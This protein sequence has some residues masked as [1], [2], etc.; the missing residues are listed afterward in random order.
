MSTKK[1][2]NKYSVLNK[3]Q[4]AVRRK[5]WIR[6]IKDLIINGPQAWRG[7]RAGRYWDYSIDF[8]Q[9][10]NYH[11]IGNKAAGVVYYLL[12][13]F[14]PLLMLVMFFLAI[15]GRNIEITPETIERF[16]SF[17]PAP[18]LVVIESLTIT[19]QS[20]LSTI[21]VLITIGMALWATS[22]GIG[23]V[24]TGI[25]SIY[26][27]REN[28]L[29]LPARMI[30]IVFTILFFILLTLATL[31]MSFGRV[32]FNFLNENLKFLDIQNWVIDLVTYGFS[33]FLI[34]SILYILYY[35]NSKRSVGKIPS[36]P[37]ALFATI[38]WIL[39]SY[40]YSFYIA[41]R[42]SLSTLYGGLA[43]IIILMLWLNFT[44]QILLCGAMINYQ[45][46]WY[47]AQRNRKYIKLSDVIRRIG[48][49]ENPF[50]YLEKNY[51]KST[52]IKS[53]AGSSASKL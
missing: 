52:D 6:I 19:I 30:G 36:A 49:Q 25:A 21:S 22:R 26:P 43:N 1:T 5:S 46:S 2:N 27:P 33:F 34:F 47:N 4:K 10:I 20:P 11:K 23:Q 40:V 17:L 50:S 16:R 51:H 35:T 44:I 7:K 24:F 38:G 48:P 9:L 42:A 39:L 53:K 29:P 8:I 18:I 37:G 31:V 45:R 41:Y 15:L 13:A 3:K 32:I 12:L 28:T 14:V